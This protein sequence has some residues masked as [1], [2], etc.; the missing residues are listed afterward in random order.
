MSITNA[1]TTRLVKPL[2]AWPTE[3]FPEV[4]FGNYRLQQGPAF[5]LPPKHLQGYLDGSLQGEQSSVL[6][7][8]LAKLD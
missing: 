4:Q 6:N 8:L 5:T 7:G 3:G 2:D 1:R